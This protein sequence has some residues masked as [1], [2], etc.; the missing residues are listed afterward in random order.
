[1]VDFVE[2]QQIVKEQLER[3][4]AVHSIEATGDT[5]E[6]AVTAAATLLNVPMRRL[7]Y[8][9]TE[10]GFGGLLGAGRKEWK[11]RA[12]ERAL[13]D[14]PA[15]TEADAGDG[16]EETE[17]PVIVDWDGEVFVRLF[18]EGAFLKVTPPH[19]KGGRISEEAAMAALL[20]REVQGLDQALVA[21]TVREAAGEY[22]RIGDYQRNSA[23]DGVLSIDITEGDMKASVTVSRPGPGGRDYSAENYLNFLH[24]NKVYYGIKEDAVA[25]L[26]DKPVYG[27]PVTLAEGD[28]V[29]DGRDAYI[30]YNFETGQNRVRLREGVNGRVNFKDLNIIQNVVENQPLAVK[31][32]AEKGRDGKSVKGTVLFAK[33]GKDIP[34]PLGKNVSV[35]EDGVTIV[36]D[37]SGQVL[38]VNGKINVE[39]VYTVDGGVNLK[40]GNIE[41]LGT[42]IVN[43]DVEDGFVI[44]AAGNIEVNG[45][46]E[47]ALIESEG[48]VVVTQGITGKG[49]GVVKAGHS[50]WAKFIENAVVETGDMVIV[51]DGIINSRVDAANRVLCQGRRAA[52][53]GGLVR[54]GEEINA[55]TLGSPVSGT[56][57]VLEAGY[58]PRLKTRLAH[59]TEKKEQVRRE[60]EELQRNIQTL[61]NIKRQRKTLPEDKE[62]AL[63]DFVAQ[64]QTLIAGI[65]KTEEDL[66]KVQAA[67]NAIKV[68]GR[69]SASAKVYPGVRI[70]IRDIREDVRNEF[71]SVTFVLENALIN[72]SP[73]EE[74]D[75]EL[76][77]AP[78]GYT[79]T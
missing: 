78:D 55:K 26:V 25:A 24:S 56:E 18:L 28:K 67:L 8:E 5:L 53:V 4:R 33:D 21:K 34:L 17:T 47:K 49:E 71:K 70:V 54:A 14:N 30:Q 39:P 44:K 6:L 57:T 22:V 40:S 52:I 38:M 46:V 23:N 61:L 76:M 66:A 73:Y 63:A 51:S 42:V 16:G 12:Y 69:V 29:V 3:D 64:R 13:A 68:R 74:T 77:K 48:S 31:I 79:A 7:E 35:G 11:I 10:R 9:I 27:E 75:K 45:T 72:A 65:K 58:D 60:F 37:I 59:L 32:A 20:Q 2:L 19:G 43:G 36:A 62:A 1:M 15:E 41:F 50:V